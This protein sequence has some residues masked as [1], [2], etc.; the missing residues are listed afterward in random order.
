MRQVGSRHTDFP[1]L[2]SYIGIL[3]AGH[4]NETFGENGIAS[5]DMDIPGK[6]INVQVKSDSIDTRMHIDYSSARINDI[7]FKG[8]QGINLLVYH[9]SYPGILYMNYPSPKQPAALRILKPAVSYW[10]YFKL[11]WL[12]KNIDLES[13]DKRN[14]DSQTSE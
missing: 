14:P 8:T 12:G 2:D 5:V 10:E 3:Q 7:F 9:P 11:A 1:V 4:I 6:G 13:H